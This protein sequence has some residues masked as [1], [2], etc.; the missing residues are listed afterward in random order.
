[1]RQRMKP[2][3]TFNKIDPVKQN[4]MIIKHF[5]QGDP[6][7]HSEAAKLGWEM[8]KLG[9]SKIPSSQLKQNK[10]ETSRYVKIEPYKGMLEKMRIFSVK[11][12]PNN[13]HTINDTTYIVHKQKGQNRYEI[14][15]TRSEK[16]YGPYKS[17]KEAKRMILIYA[18]VEG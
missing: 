12:E 1:M 11:Q 17:E 7:G 18:I 16:V 8:R 13:T 10:E 5:W 9:Y 4:R 6:E 15:S 14:Y 2:I 3:I